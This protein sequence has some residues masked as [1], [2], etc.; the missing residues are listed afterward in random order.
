MFRNLGRFDVS[1]A[2][3]W[4]EMPELGSKARILLKPATDSNKQYYNAMLR[5]SG[6]RAR[7]MARTGTVSAEDLEL[8][9]DEDRILFPKYVIAGWEKVETEEDEHRSE[10]EKEYVP[11]SRA[12]AIELCAVLPNHLFDR[13]RNFAATPEQF[14]AEDELLPDED[15]LAGN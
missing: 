13:I 11:F 6:K 10:D 8:N 9:R 14:Y 1:Q 12:N 2:T 3:A 7:T 5:T 4:L 15:E